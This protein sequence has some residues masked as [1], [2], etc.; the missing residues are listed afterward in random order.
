MTTSLLDAPHGAQRPRVECRPEF[1]SSAGSEAVDLA[2]SCGVYLDDWQAYSLEQGLGEREDG[3]WASFEVGVC[4]ARQN[5]KGEIILARELAG[6]LLFN[7]RLIMHSAHEYK[8]AAEGFLRIQAVFENNDWLRKLVKNIRTSHGEEGIELKNG[9]RLRFVARSKGSGR[10]FTGDCL[11]FDEAMF[12][13]ASAM[14]AML[15]TLS[16]RPNPQVWYLGSAGTEES[17]QFNAVRQRG[18]A[19]SAGRLTYMEWSAPPGADPTDLANVALANPALGHRISHEFVIGERETLPAPE[20][21]RE[22]LSI[23]S[24]GKF[25]AVIDAVSW[26]NQADPRSTAL[27]PVSFGLAASADRAWWTITAAGLK[28]GGGKH[29]EVVAVLRGAHLVADKVATLTKKWRNSGVVIDPAGT[30]ASMIGELEAKGVKVLQPQLR[31]VAAACGRILDDVNEQQ[32]FHLGQPV[33]DKAV[34]RAGKR[35]V[36]NVWVWDERDPE[37]DVSPLVSL[38]LALHGLSTVRDVTLSVW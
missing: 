33:L 6:L 27:D 5:G 28:P 8:T 37:C 38:T 17:T 24:E 9:N 1:L 31:E 35:Q 15:P 12:L 14:A 2:A 4:V 25:L 13:G 20:Y 22:R 23:W 16:S 11:I 26:A 19:G 7:E 34:L 10:G 36:G 29:G 32:L 30:A 3:R 18:L 21:A